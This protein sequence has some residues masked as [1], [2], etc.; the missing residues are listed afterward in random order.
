MADNDYDVE[1]GGLMEE[2]E[3][4]VAPPESTS[5]RKGR[6]IKDREY[7]RKPGKAH[8]RDSCDSCKEGGDLLCC[9]RCPAS[10]HLLCHDPPLEDE[11]VPPGE[12][13][14]HRCVTR[15][16]NDDDD[17]ASTCSSRSRQ[18]EQSVSKRSGSAT[19]PSPAPK[20]SASHMSSGLEIQ[21]IVQD[22][23]LAIDELASTSPP[24]AGKP[25]HPLSILAKAAGYLNPKQF[26][27]PTEAT[28][29]IEFPGSTKLDYWTKNVSKPKKQPHEMDN[30]MVPL[31]AKLCFVCCK[32]CRVAPLLQC[33]YCPLLFHLDCLDPPLAAM[34]P[35]HQR[36]MCPNHVE[37]ALD[38][39]LLNTLKVSERVKLW[40]EYAHQPIDQQTIK[41]QFLKKIHRKNPPFRWKVKRLGRK[42][43]AVPVAIKSQYIF[44]PPLLNHKSTPII[45]HENSPNSLATKEEQEN[46]LSCVVH[47]HSDIAKHLAHSQIGNAERNCEGTSKPTASV[48][49]TCKVDQPTPGVHLKKDASQM[50]GP[51]KMEVDEDEEEV[52]VSSKQTPP[53]TN[54]VSDVSKLEVTNPGFLRNLSQSLQNII[55]GNSEIDL[56]G[57]DKHLIQVLAWQRLQQL[58]LADEKK[59]ATTAAVTE[60]VSVIRARAVLYPIAGKGKP[61][62]MCYRTLNIGTGANMDVCLSDF[63]H[64]N[65]V[66]AKHATIF[67]DESSRHYELLNY[68]EHGTTVDNVLYSC[69]FSEKASNSPPPSKVVAQVR[70]IIKRKN[71][72]KNAATNSVKNETEAEKVKV[73]AEDV[74]AMSSRGHKASQ[75]WCNCKTS[76][77]SLIG[78]SGAGWEGTAVLHH[79]STLKLGCLQFVFS[80]VG[81]LSVDYN[82][83]LSL[84]KTELTA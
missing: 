43:L 34:P 69:D 22:V 21:D 53:S 30:G 25:L 75:A 46:W 42:T 52:R 71:G 2:I 49:P 55:E 72:R 44:P 61:I 41:I 28:C 19:G 11:D 9:D 78:G 57:L 54:E 18:S 37:H 17:A 65:F 48:Q 64:C 36:W 39:E 56:S 40:D 74:C 5:P 45:P 14:C 51:V 13:L 31:P 38:G 81:D 26:E 29:S 3:R 83:E 15:P 7:Y 50:N 70:K 80:I 24:G 4:L 66:S 67:Y 76:S 79:S 32:S 33:D 58:Q 77:S 10:F 73:K 84:L 12:W 6:K 59:A 60:Q 1:S 82:K 16:Q 23:E 27:L 47:L 63:G 35:P 8:N 68:S 20:A 62:N